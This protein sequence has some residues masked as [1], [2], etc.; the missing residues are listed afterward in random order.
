VFERNPIEVVSRIPS[1]DTPYDQVDRVQNV[2][3]CPRRKSFVDCYN[4]R[5]GPSR[6]GRPLRDPHFRQLISRICAHSS[7]QSPQVGVLDKVA[8]NCEE[9]ANASMY[10]LLAN[11]TAAPRYTDNTDCRPR[12]H[13][14]ANCAQRHVLAVIGV[15]HMEFEGL[16]CQHT[17]RVSRHHDA[18]ESAIAAWAC[19]LACCRLSP[20]EDGQTVR[21]VP[22]CT[23]EEPE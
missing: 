8:V 4:A 21:C 19:S 18:L 12:E 9:S 3:G 2:D 1:V 14:Q 15:L 16:W 10:Q 6:F 13:G 23:L 17:T 22:A 20:P 11:M 5:A 7:N